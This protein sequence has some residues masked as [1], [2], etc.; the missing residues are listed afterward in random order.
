MI[1]KQN[2]KNRQTSW[3]TGVMPFHKL[4]WQLSW[5][6]FHCY[7]C[8]VLNNILSVDPSVSRESCPSGF[9]FHLRACVASTLQQSLSWQRIAPTYNTNLSIISIRWKNGTIIRC[10]FCVCVS[11]DPQFLQHLYMHGMGEIRFLLNKL[12][13]FL[14]YLECFIT[15]IP[16]A[17]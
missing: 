13:T 5:P 16:G 8:A 1:K 4:L 15:G 17:L 7:S 6:D 2:K 9:I 11:V 10:H 3:R 14:S 12:F